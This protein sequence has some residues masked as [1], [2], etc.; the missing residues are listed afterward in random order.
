M[1]IARQR[2]KECLGE[3][4]VMDELPQKFVFRKTETWQF[5][6]AQSLS[7]PFAQ[8]VRRVCEANRHIQA[9]YLLDTRKEEGS[10]LKLTIALS[11]DDEA[12]QMDSAVIQLQEMLREFPEVARNTA[13]MSAKPFEQDYAGAEF[14]FRSNSLKRSVLSWLG[15]MK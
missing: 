1:F 12:T 11:L 9:C 8:A 15:R 13:I 14:Y 7:A 2:R 6:R 4:F 10:D 3:G 5:R